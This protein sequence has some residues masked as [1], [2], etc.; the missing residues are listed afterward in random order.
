MLIVLF[1]PCANTLS[2]LLIVAESLGPSDVIVVLGGGVN[3]DGSLSEISL[4]RVWY[5]VRLFK[6]GYAPLLLF[7]TGVT[8]DLNVVSEARRMADAALD[9]GVPPAM[10]FLE[11]R[12]TRTAENAVEVAKILRAQRSGAVLLVTHPTHMRRAVAAFRRVGV[13]VR[14]APTDGN[15]INARGPAGRGMLFFKVAYEYAA[16]ALYWW[17]GWV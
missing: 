13:V 5:G 6:H 1:T 9:M 7:S 16:W 3:R 11:E 14:P 4:R 10:I 17:K 12:S 15:E 2:R 8:S